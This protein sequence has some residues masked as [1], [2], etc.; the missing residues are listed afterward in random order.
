MARAPYSGRCLPPYRRV[1]AEGT[2]DGNAV[3]SGNG[4]AGT[5]AS[6]PRIPPGGAHLSPGAARAA[7]VRAPSRIGP[8][9]ILNVIGR[10]G[11]GVVFR[12]QHESSGELVALKQVLAA[13]VPEIGSVR[14][15]ID[16]LRR[17]HHPGVVSIIAQGVDAGVPW[18]A[19]ELLE[20]ETLASY[21]RRLW[22][23]GASQ[24]TD[25]RTAP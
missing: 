10:G 4:G 22:T 16:A 3:Q 17:L 8:Y 23:G 19:M 2:N 14:R 7:T 5:L 1:S 13:S 11:T 12:A 6:P 21:A 24:T 20:G 25:T 18:Y 9:L 15:E